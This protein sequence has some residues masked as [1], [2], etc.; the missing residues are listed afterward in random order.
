MINIKNLGVWMDHSS[1]RLIEVT[2]FSFETKVIMSKFTH[3]DKMQSLNKNENLMHNKEQHQ[4]LEYYKRVG[5]IIQDYSVVILFGPTNAKTELFNILKA[6]NRFSKVKIE[7][8][9]TDKMTESQQQIFVKDYF[10]K[11]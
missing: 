8:E 6:D 11:N 7:V 5:D 2:K 4:Q 1:A 9:Q 10:T 3:D